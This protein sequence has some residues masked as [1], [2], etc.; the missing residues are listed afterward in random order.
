MES[1]R[2]FSPNVYVR[3][4]LRHNFVR[5]PMVPIDPDIYFI[6]IDKNIIERKQLANADSMKGE[7]LGAWG[8]TDRFLEHGFGFCAISDVSVVNWCT[9]EYL[10]M[11][12]CG[13]GVETVKEFQNKGVASTTVYH[14]IEKCRQLN[15][16]P[17]W[18]SW[19]DNAPSIKLA[20]KQGFIKVLDY[21][22]IHIS[23]S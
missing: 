14:F 2:D 4:L 21:K 5:N 16:V 19:R 11:N 9:A 7:I 22:I 23:K 18:D 17:Y 20:E 8:T 1:L 3:T 10:S 6:E 15:V 13:I 12:S